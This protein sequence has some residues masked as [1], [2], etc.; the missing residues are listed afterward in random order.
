MKLIFFFEALNIFTFVTCRVVT[1]LPIS[2][3]TRVKDFMVVLGQKD[4][5]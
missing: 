4:L 5:L 2:F 1:A 3:L